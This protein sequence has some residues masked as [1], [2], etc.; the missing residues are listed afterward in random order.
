MAT[1][2]QRVIR[3]HNLW[4]DSRTAAASGRKSASATFAPWADYAGAVRDVDDK[5]LVTIISH[6][7][8]VM[9]SLLH[10]PRDQAREWGDGGH[11]APRALDY[12][13]PDTSGAITHV[14]RPV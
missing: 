9:C 13:S 7:Q 6:C 3:V 11:S 5:Y 1:D 8:K 12:L 4:P 14:K 2:M 10:T